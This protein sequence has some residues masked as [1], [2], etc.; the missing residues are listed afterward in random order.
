MNIPELAIVIPAYKAEYLRESLQSIAG[1]TCKDFVV[2]VGDDASPFDIEGIV[3]EYE[4]KMEIRYHRFENNLGGKDLVAQWERCVRLVGDENWIWLFS[5]DDVMQ[6]GC[7][8]A[9]YACNDKDHFDV[10]HFDISIID[11]SGRIIREC[12]PFSNVLTSARFYSDLYLHRIDARLPEFVFKKARL[13]EDGFV[14]FDLGWRTDNATVMSCASGTGILT[15]SGNSAKVHWR[16]GSSNISVRP[17]LK[18]RKNAATIDFFNWSFDFFGGKFSWP[19]PMIYQLKCILFEFV[20]SDRQSFW[21][22]CKRGRKKLKY[23]SWWNAPI[24]YFL[25]FYRIYYRRFDEAE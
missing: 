1:Q 22:D 13:I 20:Y 11:G 3:K 18:E 10:L 21:S 14:K 6:P 25:G 4:G 5:D 16:A 9:F 17:E 8:S 7:V 12:A 15:L 23:V 24:W 19:I 2:Y